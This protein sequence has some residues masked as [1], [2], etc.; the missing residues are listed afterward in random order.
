MRVPELCG[1]GPVPLLAAASKSEIIRV[2]EKTSGY[3]T[4]AVQTREHRDALARIAGGLWRQ[5]RMIIAPLLFSPLVLLAA[6][7]FPQTYVAK[8]L[9]FLQERGGARLVGVAEPSADGVRDKQ[10]AIEALLKSDLVLSDVAKRLYAQPSSRRETAKAIEDL[11]RKVS[12]SSAG[13]DFLEIRLE[14]PAA[15]G[16]GD[17]LQTLTSVLLETLMAQG[18]QATAPSLVL[19][20]YRRQVEVAQADLVTARN[21]LA[22]A[23]RG[24]AEASGTSRALASEV[25]P[26]AA[27]APSNTDGLQAD[28]RNGELRVQET[29]AALVSAEERYRKYNVQGTLG[30]LTAPE[31]IL[32]VDPPSD[33]VAAKFSR[34]LIALAG[35][36]ALALS[37]VVLALLREVTDPTVRNLT[38]FEVLSGAPI[39]VRLPAIGPTVEPQV[40]APLWKRL[41]FIFLAAVA[42]LLLVVAVKECRPGK[43]LGV[44]VDLRP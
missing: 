33:P 16:L 37:G 21:R 8:T 36:A 15:N 25:Q 24:P 13:P 14:G 29:Q 42:T 26:G 6:S 41:L 27:P 5:R 2:F 4:S 32:V 43:S 18:G 7:V 1:M 3:F 10:P 39:I 40:T 20:R 11:R 17:R 44:V 9:L 30:L 22:Y 12:V 35:L 23:Q 34:S 19:Q 31:R 38:D 28:I